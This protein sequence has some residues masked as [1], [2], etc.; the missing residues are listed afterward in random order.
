MKL[1]SPWIYGKW[2]TVLLSAGMLLK[3]IRAEGG[4]KYTLENS[5]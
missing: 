3:K 1:S 5:E 4:G 2:L